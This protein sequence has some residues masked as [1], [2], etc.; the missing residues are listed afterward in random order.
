MI[1]ISND[2]FQDAITLTHFIP[3]KKCVSVSCAVV[4]QKFGLVSLHKCEK[5]FGEVGKFVLQLH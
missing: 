3:T 2:V 5:H 4:W 1:P